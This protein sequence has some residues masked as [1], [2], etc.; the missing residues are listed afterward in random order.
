LIRIAAGGG[1]QVEITKFGYVGITD[2]RNR[3]SGI[4]HLSKYSLDLQKLVSFLFSL[5]IAYFV[6][7]HIKYYCRLLPAG[8]FLWLLFEPEDGGDMFLRNV[9]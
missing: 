6:D 2:S 4:K 1:K 7:E 5:H 9:A 3:L 8:F